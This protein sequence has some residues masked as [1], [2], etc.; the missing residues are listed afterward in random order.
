MRATRDL[1]LK[2]VQVETPMGTA[3]CHHI[4][5]KKLAVVPILA[6]A[7]AWWTEWSP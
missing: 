5:G 6:P 1:P 4:A 2:E 7:S 3:T